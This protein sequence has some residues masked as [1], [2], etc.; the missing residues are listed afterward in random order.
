MSTSLKKS[1][2]QEVK[3]QLSE[4]YRYPSEPTKPLDIQDVKANQ[5]ALGL[6]AQKIAKLDPSQKH[7]AMLA[8]SRHI[9]NEAEDSVG[10]LPDV[11]AET[12]MFLDTEP[13]KSVLYAVKHVP[14]EILIKWLTSFKKEFD[15]ISRTSSHAHVNHKSSF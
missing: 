14:N 1:I 15:M 11:V 9:A 6:I 4:Q 3:R 5:D 8:L 2:Q 10:L 12:L 13:Q 7:S